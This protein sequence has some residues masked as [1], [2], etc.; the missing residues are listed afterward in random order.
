MMTGKIAS[1]RREPAQLIVRLSRRKTIPASEVG[2]TL[3]IS[4]EA[5]AELDRIQE[6]TNKAAQEGQKFYWH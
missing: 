6:E 3:T 5:R 2:V 1:R 4:D